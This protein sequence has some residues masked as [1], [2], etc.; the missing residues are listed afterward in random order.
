L[1]TLL[2]LTLAIWAGISVSGC[3]NANSLS[4]Q[5]PETELNPES[6]I[7]T[8]SDEQSTGTK[9]G[10]PVVNLNADKTVV[11]INAE[12][13]IS[14]ET[15][16]PEGA[17]LEVIWDAD[18]GNLI[19]TTNSRAT[20]QAP[21]IGTKATVSCTATDPE[22]TSARAEVQIEVLADSTYQITIMADRSALQTR[23][24]SQDS[25]D[26]Y[27]PVSGAKV[28]MPSLG[29]TA[30]TDSSGVAQFSINQS[31]SVAT[32]AYTI[33]KHLDWEV[34][35]YANLKP[36]A[37]SNRILD[38]LSFA[39]GYD[40]I[41][42]AI[43]RGDSFNPNRGSV[44]VTTLE[45]SSGQ[46][47]PVAEVT[48]DAGAA[49]ALSSHNTGIAIVN[50]VSRNNGEINLR[51][52][53]TGYQT[54]DG[55]L[56]PIAIDGV[57]LVRARLEKSGK[58]PDTEA[59]VSWTKPYNYQNSFPVS[60]PF[61]IGFGQAMEQNTIFD[62]VSLMIQ[63][64]ESGSM[65]ALQ[66]PAIMQHFRVVWKTSS[67][68][69]LFPKK[70]LKPLT[71]YSLLISNWIARA[72]DGRM[73]KNYNGLYGEFTTD[74]DLS[75]KIL[76]TSPVNGDTD[77]GRSG[78][79][80]VRFDRSMNPDSL[81]EELEIEITNLKSDSKIVLDGVSLK[82]QF[83]VTW[84]EGNSLLELVPYRMLAPRTTYLVKLKHTGLVTESGKK[85]ENLSD[86]WGQFTTSGL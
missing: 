11:G 57:T 41:S 69:Q 59:I 2:F 84:K 24:F 4:S 15:L 32:S 56:V 63:N 22:G 39:P 1:K 86:I 61:E 55:Y 35:Y 44:E 48:V 40:N 14:A 81:Y 83:S 62:Q 42:V 18:T 76:Q 65:L 7:K 17:M 13:T 85:A 46:T 34:A 33:I 49:Q 21:E 50:S 27:V 36:S 8:G 5:T 43:G 75:P 80:T 68:V 45:F 6:D 20:W 71:R 66:G 58:M 29:Q 73:L 54:I 77:I 78:P 23:K 51:L 31:E 67:I 47:L 53:K 9:S 38:S 70:P 10:A 72:A 25:N 52:H 28:E 74:A 79:F 12:V 16:D 82:S 64:K 30:V 37:G 60:G 19:S 26:M 3:S